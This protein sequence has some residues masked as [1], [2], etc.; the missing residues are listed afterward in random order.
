MKRILTFFILLA[1]ITGCSQKTSEP[2]K[3]TAT[4]KEVAVSPDNSNGKAEEKVLANAFDIKDAAPEM[5]N[6]SNDHLDKILMPPKEEYYYTSPSSV[7]TFSSDRFTLSLDLEDREFKSDSKPLN[8]FV[9]T[10]RDESYEQLIEQGYSKKMMGDRE[11]LIAP[12]NSPAIAFAQDGYL[13]ILNSISKLMNYHGSTFSVEDLITAAYNMSASSDFK[14]YF[15]VR[16]DHY[17]LPGYFTN[18]GEEPYWMLVGYEDMSQPFD[19]NNQYMQ[20]SNNTLRFMQSKVNDSYEPF[21]TKIQINNNLGYLEDSTFKVVIN[22][23]LY[24]INIAASSVNQDTGKVTKA[25][26]ANYEEEIERI[27]KS[28]EF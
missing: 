13:Y 6:K 25:E 8:V 22:K 26:V 12:N 17:N 23:R 5:I 15:E 7:L 2:H 16:E 19:Q 28:I 10:L 1:L 14:Q 18:D 21:G 4:L 20:I 9:E 11:Y 27:V 24:T 3:E